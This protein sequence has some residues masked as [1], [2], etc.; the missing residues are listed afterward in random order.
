[1]ST[2]TLRRKPG[3]STKRSH[4][5]PKKA[6]VGRPHS[7]KVTVTTTIRPDLKQ[8]AAQIGTRKTVAG[9]TVSDVS[10]GIER[11]LEFYRNH[12]DNS[13]STAV[14]T[15]GWPIGFFERTF[16]SWVGDPLVR[17]PQGEY[18]VREEQ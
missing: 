5:P 10:A 12:Q 2:T 18:E 1:M 4:T 8:L 13:G 14:D 9:K 7:G 16:G 15:N 11:A 17:E 3:K 6:R